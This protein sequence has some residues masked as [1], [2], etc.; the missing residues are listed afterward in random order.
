VTSIG[1]KQPY[2]TDYMQITLPDV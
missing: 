2:E 1:R